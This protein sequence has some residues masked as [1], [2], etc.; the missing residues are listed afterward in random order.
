MMR[1][2]IRCSVRL[3]PKGVVVETVI[4]DACGERN[5]QNL[6]RGDG[7]LWFEPDGKTYVYYTPTH[8]RPVDA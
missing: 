7:Q 2:W 8:W 3:P 5:R 1:D 6:R 4:N